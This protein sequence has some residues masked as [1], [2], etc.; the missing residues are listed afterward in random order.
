M[1]RPRW[2]SLHDSACDAP[3]NILNDLQ[4]EFGLT[5]LFAAHNLSVVE[6]IL[7]RVKELQVEI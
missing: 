1:A 2:R 6:H 7:T 3:A 4:A 5:Y